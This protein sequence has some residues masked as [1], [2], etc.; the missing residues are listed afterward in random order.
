MRKIVLMSLVVSLAVVAVAWAASTPAVG[1]GSATAISNS[2]AVLHGTVNPDGSST[3]YNFQYGPTTAY[4]AYSKTSHVSG[5]AAAAITETLGGL[6]PGTLYHYRIEATNK[7]GDA[8]GSDHTF[9]TTGHPP[10]GA[11]TGVASGVTT[12]MVTLTG[13][14]VT[15][16]QTTSAYFEYGP[17]TAYGLQTAAQTVTTAATPTP[18]AATVTD[19]SPGTTLHY[20]LVAVH[21]GGVPEYGADMAFTTIPVTRFSSKVTARTSPSRARR[22]PYLFTTAGTVV[23]G[24]PFP[25]GYGCSGTV[26]VR[27][28]FGHRTVA[29]RKAPVQST[30]VYAAT[31]LFRHLID[32]TKTGLR[33]EVTFRGNPY[34]RASR[35]RTREVKLG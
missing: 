33:V 13:A 18:V 30:C 22:K 31:V 35:A 9:T 15:N 8:V 24:V 1:T 11:V 2:G 20:R 17:T 26:G 16:G 3:A 25:P 23:P 29:F 7:L 5:S 21:S 32:H 19:L 4:G 28:L 34:L 12:T 27:F 10:P 6:T 14:V